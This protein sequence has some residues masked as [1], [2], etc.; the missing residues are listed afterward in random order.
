MYYKLNK[1]EKEQEVEAQKFIEEYGEQA[2]I[3]QQKLL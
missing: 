1:K 2:Y 3:E